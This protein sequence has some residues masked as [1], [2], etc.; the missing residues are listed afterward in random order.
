MNRKIG[1]FKNCTY[2]YVDLKYYESLKSSINFGSVELFNM[3]PQDN[4]PRVN[5]PQDIMP[6]DNM[7]AP[8]SATRDNMPLETIRPETKCHPDNVPP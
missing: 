1:G 8:L 2:I 6:R 3:M 4:T 7:P 5:M